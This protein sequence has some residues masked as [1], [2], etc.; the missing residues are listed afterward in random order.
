M[1]NNQALLYDSY[2]S[3][4]KHA[5]AANEAGDNA[6]ARKYFVLAAETLRELAKVSEGEL[7]K[8]R[9]ETVKKLLAAAESLSPEAR[10]AQNGGN[11]Q[12]GVKPGRALDDPTDE[13]DLDIANPNQKVSF[14]DII[15][16]QDAKI[17]IHRM[18]VYPM[19]NP[20]AYK[21]YGLST[22]GNILLEGPP[23]TGKTT[24]AKAAACEINLPFVIVTCSTLVDCLIGNTSKNISKMFN[25]VRRLIRNR[26]TPVILFCDEFDKIAQSRNSDDKTAAEAVPE[27]IQQLDGFDSNNEN[28]VIL[29]ATN[30][31]DALDEAVLSRFGKSIYIPLPTR[32]ERKQ[33]FMSKL[34]RIKKEDFETI[35]FDVLADASNDMS[36]R[37]IHNIGIEVASIM[38][39]RDIGIIRLE[40]TLTEVILDLIAQKKRGY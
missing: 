28:M 6:K 18:L 21:E 34:K 10:V 23:G 11:E 19:Q 17:A 15:G 14:D 31:K 29:A 13:Y 27:L 25:E 2:M 26:K 5:M 36:G 7:R 22:G 8:S 1:A 24:F 9:L 35:D 16:L 40:N 12:G 39:E 20:E 30:R 37:D 3:Y 38:V 32:D 33:I 4:Y